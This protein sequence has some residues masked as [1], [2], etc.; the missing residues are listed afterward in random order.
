MT[1]Y[2]NKKNATENQKGAIKLFETRM[3]MKKKKNL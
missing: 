3:Y 2:I 1:H